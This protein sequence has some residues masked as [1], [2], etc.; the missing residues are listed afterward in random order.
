MGGE[1]DDSAGVPTWDGAIATLLG[2][3]PQLVSEGHLTINDTRT[4]QHL[5]DRPKA[6]RTTRCPVCLVPSPVDG[7]FC[8]ETDK[9]LFALVANHTI[10]VHNGGPV[11]AFE[12]AEIVLP[13]VGRAYR[14]DAKERPWQFR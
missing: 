13:H 1:L 6:R 10:K 7:I 12:T 14:K 3:L 11:D 4:I 2:K 8:A 5:A 9:E